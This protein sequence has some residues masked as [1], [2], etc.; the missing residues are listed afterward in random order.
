MNAIIVTSHPLLL[1]DIAA[2]V[3]FCYGRKIHGMCDNQRWSR[4]SRPRT[5]KNPRPRPSTHLVRI[6]PLKANDRNALGQGPRT[7][8]GSVLQSPN[9]KKVFTEKI[10]NANFPLNAGDLQKIGLRSKIRKFFVIQAFSN[11]KFKRS[12][13][14]K[15][16]QKFFSHALWRASRRNNIAHD[17]D[18]F[19]TSQ[20]IVLCSGRG[21]GI[22]EDLQAS[23]STPRT[24]P[25]RPRTSN[26]VLEAKD[27]LGDSTSRN[28][29]D[30]CV[31]VFEVV[32]SKVIK[33][34]KKQKR[35]S[36]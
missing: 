17:L 15:G 26:C 3:Q 16:L 10:R 14:K 29:G 35:S 7:Q 9:K 4:G 23:R 6:D 13:N 28:N 5:Q 36:R 31:T 20:K 25:S 34:V 21:Q 1:H 12:P 2:E 33:S 19:S 32:S 30:R 11:T 27:V 22:F 18:S 8:R 24:R